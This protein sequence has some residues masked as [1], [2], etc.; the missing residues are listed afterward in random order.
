M[1]LVRSAAVYNQGRLTL[2]YPNLVKLPCYLG[3]EGD[4]VEEE[5]EMDDIDDIDDWNFYRLILLNA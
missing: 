4:N 5:E 2:F 1:C 3:N